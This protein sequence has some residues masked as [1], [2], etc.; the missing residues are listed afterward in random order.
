M[1]EEFLPI[2]WS[3]PFDL[4]AYLSITPAEAMVRGLYFSDVSSQLPK[5]KRRQLYLPFRQYP[6][7]D[8]MLLLT[9]AALHLYPE[10]S[11]R[12]G[13]RLVG[14]IVM[15]RFLQST[16]GKVFSLLATDISSAIRKSAAAMEAVQN[17]G[18]VRVVREEENA[19]IVEMRGVWDFADSH[20]V[21]L[22]EAMVRTRE[23]EPF[24]A[25][26]RHT[27]SDVDLRI[28]WR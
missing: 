1:A 23:C 10:R 20:Y 13:L 22:Y 11:R 9:D 12:E 21:G 28:E 6:A 18:E 5:D 8:Y 27:L 7:R 26:K 4:D 3:E 24:I 17:Y 15:S 16:V 25:M 14:D 19:S 2:D